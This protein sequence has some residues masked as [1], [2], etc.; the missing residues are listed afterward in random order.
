LQRQKL[1]AVIDD[2]GVCGTPDSS[3]HRW[4]IR[5][6]IAV[7]AEERLSRRV[8]QVELFRVHP[9]LAEVDTAA[10]KLEPRRHAVPIEP[11][12]ILQYRRKPRIRRYAKK[13]AVQ[14]GRQHAFDLQILDVRFHA[15]WR[16]QSL[17]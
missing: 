2:V 17:E 12:V 1:T 5:Q 6:G 7:C 14:F 11:D 9:A 3:A 13:H 10:P 8:R 4:M 16:E 15:R